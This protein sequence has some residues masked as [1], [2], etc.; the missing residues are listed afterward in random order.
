MAY[1]NRYDTYA[2]EYFY[3]QDVHMLDT[4]ANVVRGAFGLTVFTD[5]DCRMVTVYTGKDVRDDN[6]MTQLRQ[7]V[8]MFGED[9]VH[10]V[11]YDYDYGYDEYL[12][13]LEMAYDRVVLYCGVALHSVD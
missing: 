2:M 5:Y 13:P 11:G 1:G 3:E 12:D 10:D 6:L 9:V 8:Q 7:V 4:V